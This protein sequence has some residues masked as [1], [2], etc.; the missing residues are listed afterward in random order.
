MKFS[1]HDIFSL[2]CKIQK[3]V[4]SMEVRTADEQTPLLSHPSTAD[5]PI[6]AHEQRR[7]ALFEFLEA[8]TAGG[9]SYE[10]FIIALIF[11]NVICFILGSLFVPETATDEDDTLCRQDFCDALFFGNYVDNGLQ[12]LNI[13]STSVLELLT[14]FIFTVEYILRIYTADLLDPSLYSG[15]SGRIRYIP[16]FFSLVDLISTV[17]FYVDAFVFPNTDY[18]VSTTAYLRMFRLFRMMRVE[19]R[20]DTAFA[21]LDDVLLGQKEILLTAGFVGLT[22]WMAVSSLYY[23]T[24]R[25]NVHMIYCP[26]CTSYDPD[27]NITIVA[28]D[29]FDPTT[30]CAMDPWGIV[31]C[32]GVSDK[33]CTD[34]YHR[35]ESI[36]MASYYALLNL[37]GEYPLIDQHSLPGKVVGTLTAV[38]AVAV[39]A[40]PV[41]I[42]GN[43]LEMALSK[44]KKQNAMTMA[45]TDAST[46]VADANAAPSTTIT[47]NFQGNRYSFRGRMYNV[48]HARTVPGAPALELFINML[49][50]ASVASFMLDTVVS[51]ANV[52]FHLLLDSFE[53]VAVLI[54]TLEYTFRV[55][56]I[57]EDPKYA[58]ASGRFRY[59]CTFLS[60]VDV[61]S[62]VPY[63]LE[64]LVL[65]GTI[66]STSAKGNAGG[67]NF[68]KS[69]RLLRILRFERYTHA[70][71][72]FDDVVLQNIDVLAVTAFSAIVFWIFFSTCLYF[73]ERHSLDEE[74]S[75][76]YRTIPSAMWITLLNLSGESPLCQYS[77]YG[78][79]I[80]A[81]LGLF[82][83]G[84]FGIPIGLLGAGFE[85]IV[86]QENEDSLQELAQLNPRQPVPT[87]LEDEASNAIRSSSVTMTW[88]EGIYQFVNGLDSIWGQRFELMVYAL[89]LLS[90]AVGAWQTVD[91]HENDFHELEWV[92]VIVFTLEYTLRFI[93]AGADPEFSHV[94]GA[95]SWSESFWCRCRFLISFYSVIDLLAI[96]PFY[97]ALALPNTFVNDYDEYFRMLRIVRLLKLDKYV[98]SITLIGRLD[99]SFLEFSLRI[100]SK[101]SFCCIHVPRFYWYQTMS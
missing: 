92:A 12:F 90:V 20:Y 74:I 53:F 60:I 47:P 43:G 5:A 65:G 26:I 82:A 73:T 22:V 3:C 64:M 97:V 48:F 35:Y 54:F 36:P 7:V 40:L 66:V 75:F 86:S 32:T 49:I 18:D 24:E 76:Y 27:T 55:Y 56:S 51:D 39:F 21:L 11:I 29:D 88:V 23:L 63:W 44:Q 59:V 10:R 57:R 34:C 93:G 41:G 95:Q 58:D 83:T 67:N 16:T 84:I 100:C 9:K 81:I 101:F 1:F 94:S 69:L 25:S 38:V 19:G 61:L 46:A 91:G 17:P 96:V 14:V 37:F 77:M 15:C 72:T 45:T 2:L 71:T 50:L 78:K 62:F 52:R 70:F 85:A 13:G 8:K 4:M 99:D 87:T 68:V 80:T 28:T 33:D 31:N 6:S 42:I 89:I 79:I 98:P 30:D